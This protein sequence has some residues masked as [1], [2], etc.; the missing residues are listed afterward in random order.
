MKQHGYKH[1]PGTARVWKHNTRQTIFCLC[2]DDLVIKYYNKEDLNHLITSISSHYKY[3]IDTTGTHYMGL[4]LNWNYDKQFVD[5]SIPGYVPKLLQKL[6]H[7]PPNKPEYAPHSHQPF[8]FHNHHQ[9]QLSTSIDTSPP[10]TTKK[11]VQRVQSIVGS[12]LYYARA[13]DNTLLPA[14]NEIA[15]YQSKPTQNIKKKCDRLLNYISTYPNVVIRYHASNMQL[16]IDSYAAYLVAPKTR[17]CVA[18]F[19]YFKHIKCHPVILF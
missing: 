19:Y 18:G 6:L 3:Y 2:A 17:S 9:R 16:S 7:E 5:I 8:N 14:L 10:L 1:D 12:L 13:I 11:D 15:A 4:T